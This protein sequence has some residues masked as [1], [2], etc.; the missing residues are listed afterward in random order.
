M[1]VAPVDIAAIKAFAQARRD[2]LLRLCAELVAAPS[3][4][5]VGDTTA[6]IAVLEGTLRA[7]GLAPELR[8]ADPRKPNIV[9]SFEGTGPGPHLVLNGH[10]DTLNPGD[11]KAW[12]VP[13]YTVSRRNGRMSGLG[14]GNMKAGTAALTEAFIA[15]HARRAEI[16]GRVSLTL[17]SDEVVFGP[18]GSAFLLEADNG[19]RG[20][21]LINAEGPGHMNL[22]VA[23]KGLLWLRIEATA[24]AGQGM[25][26]GT[27]SSAIARLARLLAEIDGW[28]DERA[29]PPDGMT[30]LADHAGEH[31]LRLSVNTGKIEGGNFV[32]QVAVKARAEVDFRVPPGLTIEVIES[33]VRVLAERIGGIT[34]ARIKGWNPNWT[35]IE[36]HL[37]QA[38]MAASAVVR[39]KPAAPV[40][41]LPASDA[42]RWRALGVPAI[43]FGPQAELASGIDDYV[44]EQDVVDCLAIY[45][46]T[47]LS[48]LSPSRA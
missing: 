26:T 27:G 31:G 39:G 37:S 41:R 3:P 21:F 6:P 1:T 5:P 25:L 13:V 8:H 44:F 48:L 9:C 35:P 24:A 28:N 16:A 45:M 47:A 22:A 23:E 34:L 40:V 7:A 11:E 14:I 46:A 12:S 32:S 4:Q 2:E 43:C 36:H 10:V 30:A 20:D 19:L 42:M 33:R 29:A 18:A 38:V 17:V 15:L